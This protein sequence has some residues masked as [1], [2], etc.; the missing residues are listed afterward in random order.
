MIRP[1]VR[2][3]RLGLVRAQ[4]NA[5]VVHVV[6]GGGPLVGDSCQE[7]SQMMRVTRRLEVHVVQSLNCVL[8]HQG[9]DFYLG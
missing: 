9:W 2:E 5:K 3:T 7:M 4:E 6:A 8:S 1:I